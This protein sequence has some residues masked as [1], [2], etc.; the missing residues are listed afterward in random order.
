MASFLIPP[1]LT[2]SNTKLTPGQLIADKAFDEFLLTTDKGV[3]LKQ[4]RNAWYAGETSFTYVHT[5]L[6]SDTRAH[7]HITELYTYLTN[8]TYGYTVGNVTKIMDKQY[9]ILVTIPQ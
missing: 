2:L 5:N 7:S 4:F 6:S 3:F 9:S 1:N 8:S